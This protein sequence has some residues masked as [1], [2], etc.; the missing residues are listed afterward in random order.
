MLIAGSLLMIHAAMLGIQAFSDM[1]TQPDVFGPT[2]HFVA[3]VGLLGLYPVLVERT[4]TMVRVAGAVA[5]IALVSWAV[6]AATRFLA[7]VGLISS[8]S[9][10]L[11]GA[12][13]VF[14]FASTILTYVLFSVTAVRFKDCPR[15]V[16]PLV[17]T[18][19]V[20]LIV[21]LVG[22][23]LSGVSDLVGFLVGCG[24]ALSILE[25]GY[26][27][28]TWSAPTDREVPAGDVTTG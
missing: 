6:M 18:P 19:A 2:G 7:V 11:P 13:F 3:L 9:D 16:G 1:S 4:P 22:S 27:L 8:L 26:T 21:A 12:F 28:R 17:L 5:G 23:A 15:S 10:V 25:L 24:L 20:L 14:L